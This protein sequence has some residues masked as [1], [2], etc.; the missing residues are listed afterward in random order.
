[1]GVSIRHLHLIVKDN[2]AQVFG[3]RRSYVE[4]LQE[5]NYAYAARFLLHLR[6]ID[7]AWLLRDVK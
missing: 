5:R 4:G 1:M 3:G 6:S 2:L 7:C